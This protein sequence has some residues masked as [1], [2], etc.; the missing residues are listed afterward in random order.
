MLSRDSRTVDRGVSV[1]LGMVL[2]V[3]IVT[4]AM[5]LLATA[6]LG[7]DFLDE[8]PSADVVYEEDDDG[9]VLIALADARGLSAGDTDIRL[10][11]VGDCATWDGSGTLGKGDTTV[12]DSSDCPDSF[13]AGDVIQVIGSDVLVDS[14]ELR[15][16]FADYGC[17]AFESELA[18]DDEIVIEDGDTVACDF[19]DDGSR[20]S[21]PVTVRDGGKLIGDIY[22][23]EQITFDDGTVDGDI[24]SSKEFKLAAESE[25]HGDI[26]SPDDGVEIE[27][28]T[29]VGGSITTASKDIVVEADGPS[30]IGGDITSG[31]DAVVKADNVVEGAITADRGIDIGD[32]TEI[33]GPI[34]AAYD[35][36]LDQHS[37]VD[38]D[39][40]LDTTGRSVELKDH[41]T[42]TGDVH[43]DDN[44]VILRDGA[45]IEGDVWGD[46]VT[47]EGDATVEGEVYADETDCT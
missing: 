13:E 45:T 27:S 7:I 25:I 31:E 30:T 26:V 1:V 9:T 11:N 2:L 16:G 20:I 28:G 40:T 36:V 18:S 15:G 44:D 35:V 12:I 14:Y 17:E 41:A 19:V 23:E 43:A 4:I 21:N 37:L 10:Q 46:T 32:S 42:V 24:D 6:I 47:C 29:D 38:A 39:V 3:G 8:S 33:Y 34:D 5:A 22:T